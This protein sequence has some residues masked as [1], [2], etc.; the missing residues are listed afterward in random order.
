MNDQFAALQ[1]ILYVQALVTVFL[2]LL[3]WSLYER[4]RRQLFHWWWAIAWSALAVYLAAGAASVA[5]IGRE[6]LAGL[7]HVLV[8]TSVVAGF[9][10]VPALVLGALHARQSRLATRRLAAVIVPLAIAAGVITYAT[11][12]LV[13]RPYEASLMRAVPRQLATAGA[14][15]FCAVAF[16]RASEFNRAASH[17][18]ALAFLAWSLSQTIYAIQGLGRLLPAL[19][20]VQV[21]MLRLLG[22]IGVGWSFVD[23]AAE[24]GIASGMALMLLDSHLRSEAEREQLLHREQ[25]LRLRAEID[26]RRSAFLSETSAVVASSL[27][28]EESLEALARAPVPFLADACVLSVAASDWRWS[29]ACVRDGAHGLAGALESIDTGHWA[30]L[31]AFGKQQAVRTVDD[32]ELERLAKHGGWS[33]A[34][35][36]L[37]PTTAL[38]A[39]VLVR[40][41]EAGVYVF[42]YTGTRRPTDRDS[43]LAEELARR[44]A[45]AID[46]ALLYREAREASRLK[47]EF[48]TVVSHEL[49]TPVTSVLGRAQWL[50]RR[51]HGDETLAR[52]L[53]EIEENA[54][55]QVGLINDLLE[56]SKIASGS[57]RLDRR[58][59]DLRD[60]VEA[61]AR[62]VRAV[63]EAKGVR[64]A[65]EYPPEPV[66]VFADPE[67]FAQV[68]WNVLA[69][70]IKF[71]PHGGEVRALAGGDVAEAWVRVSDTGAGID[72]KFLPHVFDR[73]RQGDGSMTRAHGGLGL[74]LAIVKH[75]VEL[76][77]GQVDAESDG[78]GKGATFTVKLPTDPSAANDR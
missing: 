18:T 61:A 73:F 72:P 47:D 74:G 63:A 27:Q 31:C 51:V 14:Y 37:A 1:L 16:F 52:G 13:D 76:H 54:R 68:V 24:L 64:L 28:I 25:A 22:T 12:L 59:V 11:A 34:L 69:N 48:L 65:V 29:R 58:S 49:R 43:S 62:T 2:S 46:N 21:P 38:C 20:G 55:A 32:G 41:K 75:I 50:R 9:A 78:P 39:T 44:A 35:L 70:A 30:S 15:I 3:F 67:R 6:D 57:L 36:R 33:E 8:A 45:Q 10:Q 53:A 56:V 42:L 4:L 19:L 71:T 60:V 77:G 7:R 23:I 26:E 66:L 5:L 17:V 40:G